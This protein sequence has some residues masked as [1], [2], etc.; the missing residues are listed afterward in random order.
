LFVL[1]APQ[2]ARGQ[3]VTYD[4]FSA[5]NRLIDGAKWMGFEFRTGPG[6]V[7]AYRRID[8]AQL[9]LTYRTFGRTDLNS[10]F[11][12]NSF[13]VAFPD[14]NLVTTMEAVVTVGDFEAINTCAGNATLSTALAGLR[15]AFFN[16]ATPTPG[17]FQNDVQV[18]L[19][20]YRR[21]SGDSASTIQVG[22]FVFECTN[23]DCSSPSNPNPPLF[24][25]LGPLSCPGRACA[26][27]RLF[28]QWEKSNKLFRFRRGT[29]EKTISYAASFPSD[30]AT[31]GRPFKVLDIQNRPANCTTGAQRAFM[32]VFFDSVNTNNLALAALAA[33]LAAEEPFLSLQGLPEE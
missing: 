1:T 27:Q 12:A 9:R 2:G 14:P 21:S 17:S 11:V 8:A 4:T 26:A 30:A 10:G 5:A 28:V 33:P 3:L 7:E 31:P 19:V 18:Y 15:G 23:A 13:G 29:V 24:E 20:L 32:D 25:N 16:T 6:G 22:A